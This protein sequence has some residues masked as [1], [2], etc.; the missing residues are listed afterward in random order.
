MDL[1]FNSTYQAA[2]KV[3]EPV[4]DHFQ[5]HMYTAQ[6][7]GEDDLATVPTA[8][9]IER[10]IDIAFWA[11]LRREEGNATRIS[12]AF[13]QPSQAGKPLLLANRIPLTPYA[14]TKLAPGVERAGIHIG[15]WYEDNELYI[16]G[17]T[18]KLP[19]LC[20]VLDVAEPGLL[21]VKHRRL[22][23]LGKFTNVAVLKGDQV[24]IVDE[25]CSMKRDIPDILSSLLGHKSSPVWNNPT[26]VLIQI[27]VSMRAHGKGGIL[28][29]TPPD[30]DEWRDS[31][32]HPLSYPISPAFSGVADLVRRD[33]RSV[34]EIFWQNALR[35]EVD[36]VSGLTAVDGATIINSR[37]ELLAFGAK[38]TRS[39][40]STAVEQVMMLEPV[41]DGRPHVVHPSGIGGTRHLSAAQFVHDQR[42]CLAL[43]ASQ[44]GY[45]TIFSW[46]PSIQ[47][48][49]GHKIDIL[50][51]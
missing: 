45:F 31:I 23:G 49:Q 22:L 34:S 2:V 14:L 10:M 26:N 17:T 18:T 4:S 20:F 37:H 24:K 51:M 47:M 33:D 13:L 46:S 41:L 48:V 1:T 30:T 19:N 50:L 32:I 5:Q 6:E 8:K 29:V 12:L 16:W 38:I 40:N 27:A 44:D 39:Y 25:G 3:A 43:V 7:N 11:S 15:I 42:N 36:N 35:R 9:I 28:L 21:V